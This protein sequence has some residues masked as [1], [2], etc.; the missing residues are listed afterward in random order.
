MTNNKKRETFN[1]VES[2]E[3]VYPADA[4]DIIDTVS[5]QLTTADNAAP[6]QR[7]ANDQHAQGYIYSLSDARKLKQSKALERRAF[8]SRL[9]DRRS[10]TRMNASGEPQLDRREANR[11]ANIE[12]IRLTHNQA[13]QADK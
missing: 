7:A 8:K 2:V 4:I 6:E 10:D 5:T 12:A 3:S 1:N 13:D 11:L 9:T